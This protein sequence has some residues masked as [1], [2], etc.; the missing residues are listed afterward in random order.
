MSLKVQL[1]TSSTPIAYDTALGEMESMVQEIISGARPSTIWFLEHEHVYTRGTSANDD[2]LLD[3]Q[4]IPVHNTGRGGKF[5]YHGPGQRVVYLMLDIKSLYD[6]HA[7]LKRY[8]RDIE[9]WL[10]SS[11]IDLGIKAFMRE[12]RVG[13]WVTED[14]SESKIAAIGI[15]VKKWVGY[16]GIA[17]NISPDLSYYRGIV[18]CG[19]NDYGVTSICK[20]GHQ[21]TIEEVDA[22]LQH[23]FGKLFKCEVVK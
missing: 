15:R 13:V 6:G 12:G 19:I 17:L 14:N 20:L 1:L 11:L 5:T 10:I 16:H 7:D 18:P 23:N 2:E 9:Q 3:T 8:I 22:V 21:V 4:A